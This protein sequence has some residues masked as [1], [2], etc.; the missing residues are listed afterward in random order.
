MNKKLLL[1]AIIFL[2]SLAF[3]IDN[4]GLVSARLSPDRFA[5][6]RD[7]RP[8][9][10]IVV[11]TDWMPA[12][13]A[14]E[15]LK[16]DFERVTGALPPSTGDRAVVIREDP[17]LKGKRETY[18]LTFVKDYAPGIAEALVIGG[19]DPRGCV[20][21]IYEL[22]EQIGVSPWYDWADASL[23]YRNPKELSI[24]RGE[25]TNGE[26]AVRYR[27]IFINDDAPCFTGWAENAY[28]RKGKNGHEMYARVGE[29]ILRLRGNFLWPEMWC[30]AFYADDPLNSKTMSDMGVIMGTSHHE[31]MAR[32]HQ[33]WARNRRQY[34]AWDYAKNQAVLDEFFAEGI[35]RA[36][37]TEDV[38]TVGMRGDGDAGMGEGTDIPLLERIIANQRSIIERETGRRADEVPQMWALYKEVQDYY[39]QGMRVPDDVT[40]LLC[41]DNWGNVRRLPDAGERRHPGGWGMY[42]HV[43]YVGAPRN[44]K[45]L[46]CTP[47]AHLWEQMR[48]TYEYG[49]DR[50][51]I[52]NVGDLKPMEYPMTLFLDMAWNPK[53]WDDGCV[54]RHTE[55]FCR[56][57]FGAEHAGEIA[58]IIT[59][60]NQL[61]GRATPELLDANSYPLDRHEG[62]PGCSGLTWAEAVADYRELSRQTAAVRAKLPA[63]ALDAY[64]QLVEFNVELMRAL[65]EMY[66]A[67]AR[68]DQA[69]CDRWFARDREV[70]AKY[71]ELKG[72][73]W[74]GMMVQKHIGYTS[75]N[76]NFPKEVPPKAW[77]RQS[78]GRDSA[79]ASPAAAMRP[80]KAEDYVRKTESA[81]HRWLEIPFTGRIGSGM[82]VVP[83]ITDP[84]GCALTYRLHVPHPADSGLASV[85]LN[86]F[87]ETRTTLPFA[88]ETGHRYK[89][90]VGG[91][92]RIVDMNSDLTE[93]KN[94]YG[95]FYPIVARRVMEKKF[96]FADVPEDFEVTIEPL[97]P[98]IVFTAVRATYADEKPRKR[99]QAREE[100]VGK[101]VL[102]PPARNTM[103]SALLRVPELNARVAAI[104]GQDIDVV[105]LGDSIT[106]RWEEQGLSAFARLSRGRTFLNLGEGG[107]STRNLRW[108]LETQG[109]LDGYRAR[110]VALLIGTNDPDKPEMTVA[111]IKDI[112]ATIRKKQPQ[113]K[114]LVCALLPRDEFPDGKERRKVNAVNDL[115]VPWVLSQEDL[116]LGDYRGTFL[117]EDNVLRTDLMSDRLHPNPQGFDAFEVQLAHDL[118][119]LLDIPSEH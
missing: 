55:A 68:G 80:V 60:A 101:T 97:E 100:S 110:A 76:D 44:S 17:S 87:V 116:V 49:V 62:A 114:I 24:A 4:P 27:G 109:Q 63:E 25:W 18:R 106:R 94:P 22:S 26:P 79:D 48:L 102:P 19:S 21:G 65:H 93:K 70:M 85:P 52:L 31:P 37:D 10:R 74:K 86:L 51:W 84:Q 113:A 15:N 111:S 73:K 9:V 95:H 8:C 28:G 2:S 77:E 39:D 41:D 46:N 71:N 58:A 6:V 57:I 14:A 5:L 119:G 23:A 56:T 96:T 78:P 91:V 35:R 7:G 42:Y 32:N 29:L 83:R 89:V 99:R 43:D 61:A 16:Q 38:I 11:E 98:G 47:N 75:W 103:E 104:K 50:L 30:W 90:T 12:K 67:Q 107:D 115:L 88:K 105:L 33:E 117:R 13:I 54:M 59:R 66:C 45:L 3:A 69:E 20:Y 108:R 1:A 92:S 64:Y 34:G 112:V 81:T 82:T 118:K 36:K 53:R 72:G 40:I